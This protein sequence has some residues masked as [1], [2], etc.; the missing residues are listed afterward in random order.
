MQPLFSGAQEAPFLG[1]SNKITQ[2]PKLHDVSYAC[3][4]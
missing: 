1:H 3:E 4:A 2:M